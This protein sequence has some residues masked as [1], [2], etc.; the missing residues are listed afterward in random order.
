[1]KPTV[2][3][4]QNPLDRHS[5]GRRSS[6]GSDDVSFIE[7]GLERQDSCGGWAIRLDLI[8]LVLILTL[9][10]RTLLAP[11]SADRSSQEDDDRAAAQEGVLLRLGDIE[12]QVDRLNASVTALVTRPSRHDDL[13]ADLLSNT[14]D[15]LEAVQ[16]Q[17][18]RPHRWVC[19]DGYGGAWC[20]DDIEPPLV[21][22]ADVSIAHEPGESYGILVASQAQATA[23]DNSLGAG[24]TMAT[25]AELLEGDGGGIGAGEHVP[26]A[27]LLPKQLA[28][29][30]VH[31]I[32]H[33]ATDAAGNEGHCTQIVTISDVD[34]CTTTG[35]CQ[36]RVPADSAEAGGHWTDCAGCSYHGDCVDSTTRSEVALNEMRCVCHDGWEGAACDDVAAAPD[37]GIDSCLSSPCQNG[38]ACA[39][40]P[41]G[42][43]C[44]C[45]ALVGFDGEECEVDVDECALA[46]T[47]PCLNGGGCVDGI[48]DY[49]CR[50]ETGWT[51]LRCEQDSSCP[52]PCESAD[53]ECSGIA[54]FSRQIQGESAQTCVDGEQLDAIIRFPCSEQPLSALQA[55][56]GSEEQI[57]PTWSRFQPCGVDAGAR[58][59]P[60]ELDL[61]LTADYSPT[62]TVLLGADSVQSQAL[63][64]ID[65][66]VQGEPAL[67]A[68]PVWDLRTH[69]VSQAFVLRGG[70]SLTLR[71]IA[72][73]GPAAVPDCFSYTHDD[74]CY[75]CDAFAEGTP[76]GTEAFWY[77]ATS[78]DCIP[79][80][81]GLIRNQGGTLLIERVELLAGAAYLGGAIQISVEP[82]GRWDHTRSVGPGVVWSSALEPQL[83]DA[84]RSVA[85][86]SGR[87]FG[88]PSVA[89]RATSFRGNYAAGN[90]CCS[91]GTVL[92]PGGAI[93][94]GTE[95]AATMALAG[96]PPASAMISVEDCAFEGNGVRP[97]A[98]GGSNA[99]LRLPSSLLNGFGFVNTTC[100]GAPCDCAGGT[101]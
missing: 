31:H 23:T 54:L 74:Y 12:A 16:S 72:I 93:D 52:A 7:P 20:D 1:M 17:L 18:G 81:G 26:L 86:R 9:I 64:S 80:A 67:P 59:A 75:F 5:A 28:F 83:T 99:A 6:T 73:V 85:S 32:R 78:G 51:G 92:D 10:A 87:G 3:C 62:D 53:G 66:V 71:D 29:G 69:L 2:V 95:T 14:S 37:D 82:L 90:R 55:A 97:P 36:T 30:V 45:S 63:V 76:F 98:A 42:Y 57:E 58:E 79:S 70:T 49:T 15:E 34:E 56:I 13:L 47:A 65:A 33:V 41:G 43:L 40:L 88:L 61:W 84:S 35:G 44:D 89:I 68:R 22:C 48:G 60:H 46:G 4:T 100:D 39:D 24:E 96:L 91:D 77:G 50:C 27:P 19:A 21:T 94:L 38:G 101:C 11:D 8:N 25:T